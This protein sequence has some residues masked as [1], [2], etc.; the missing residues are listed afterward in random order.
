MKT[1][2]AAVALLLSLATTSTVLARGYDH[3][4]HG[5]YHYGHSGWRHDH[6]LGIVLGVAGGLLLGSAL[7]YS[8]QPPQQVVVYDAPPYQPAV[9]VPQPS[10]CYE[11]RLV[12][13]EWQVS[14]YDGRQI[15]VSFPN[16]VTRTV[17]VPCN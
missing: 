1:K 15:W 8:V 11:E 12:Y 3:G 17:Q 5:G 13:G 7:L 10:I 14:K 16:P 9:V 6:D 4:R 2:I